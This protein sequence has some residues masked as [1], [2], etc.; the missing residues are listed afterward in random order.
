MKL[1]LCCFNAPHTPIQAEEKIINNL[2]DISD[3]KERVYVKYNNF[4]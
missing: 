4:G 3:K 1:S 2:S